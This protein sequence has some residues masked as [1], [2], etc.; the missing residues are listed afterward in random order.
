MSNLKTMD[1]MHDDLTRGEGSK[2]ARMKISWKDATLGITTAQEANW[3]TENK[4]DEKEKQ[5]EKGVLA[6]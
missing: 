6:E 4:I 5:E 2:K 3:L 1:I